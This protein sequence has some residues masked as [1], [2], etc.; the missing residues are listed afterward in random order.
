MIRNCIVLF[1]C[2]VLVAC[3]GNAGNG[4]QTTAGAGAP[5][6]GADAQGA[7][8]EETAA[9]EPVPE[10]GA[11]V[12][13]FW[14]A[15]SET[16][17]RVMQEIIDDFNR[18]RKDWFVKMTLFESD[19]VLFNEVQM[20]AALQTLP[21]AAI[22]DR[23]SSAELHR[24]NQTVELTR[25]MEN[26]PGFRREQYM[27]VYFEQGCEED[28]TIYAM[29][30]YG[31]TKVMFY[32]KDV[33]AHVSLN[34]E[35]METW[36]DVAKAADRLMQ[37][38]VSRYGWELY[39]GYENL[40]DASLSNGGS[41]FSED[42]RTVTFNS[43]EWVEVWEQF[44][45]WMHEE[46][47]MRIHSGGVGEEWLSLTQADVLGGLAGGY[48]GSSWNLGDLDKDKVGMFVQPKWTADKNASPGA[49]AYL[50]NL[51]ATADPMQQRGAHEWLKYLIEV[52]AQVKFMTGTGYIAVNRNILTSPI[53]HAHIK[54][55]PEMSVLLQQSLTAQPYPIDPTGDRIK[56]ILRRAADRLQIENLPA[57]QVLDDAQIEAQRALD[58]VLPPLPEEPEEEAGEE[59]EEADVAP[60]EDEGA[61]GDETTKDVTPDEAGEPDDATG[62]AS[63]AGEEDTE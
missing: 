16:T 6:N 10:D 17:G 8:A 50:F 43:P 48:T 7:D 58:A 20:A 25:F 56:L 29:S 57:R 61:S 47:L 60:G 14:M 40:L 4:A 5:G 35:N 36:K 18:S 31:R 15:G 54:E 1:L 52:P 13:E 37:R 51:F 45:V 34:P 63:D 26:T 3:S 12:I 55:Y 38:R 30:L 44:R 32:N 59:G 24:K 49:Y 11:V 23:N 39:W 28:G 27:P 62:E 22:L 33:F 41:L 19:D 21:V 46:N 42:G 9:G 2:L 53:Y